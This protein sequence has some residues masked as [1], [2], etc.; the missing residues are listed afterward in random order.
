MFLKLKKDHL[1]IHVQQSHIKQQAK[2][3][4]RNH[5]MLYYSEM[6]LYYIFKNH[7]VSRP[8][9]YT[10]FVHTAC[11]HFLLNFLLLPF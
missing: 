8:S 10:G 4:H 7:K 11:L 9:L 3:L 1:I 5:T 6:L 2:L